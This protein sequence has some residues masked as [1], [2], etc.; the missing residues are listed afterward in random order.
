MRFGWSPLLHSGMSWLRFVPMAA[1]RGQWNHVWAGC[2]RRS[3]CSASVTKLRVASSAQRADSAG[4]SRRGTA[5]A[6]LV[7]CDLGQARHTH[8]HGASDRPQVPF[9][10]AGI[11]VAA[12]VSLVPEAGSL[13]EVRGQR[14]VVAELTPALCSSRTIVDLQSVEDGRHGETLP[15]SGWWSR[16]SA[17][18][19]LAP[20][21]RWAA[22][23]THRTGSPRS[24][25]RCAGRR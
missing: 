4:E 14:W 16:A 9:C 5:P 3:A 2:S 21:R 20:C 22:A 15:S 7:T 23:S 25:T 10:G 18:C 13:V 6:G 12:E 24:W 11:A 17:C 1:D 8:R 19:L